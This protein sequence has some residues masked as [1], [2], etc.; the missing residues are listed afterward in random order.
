MEYKDVIGPDEVVVKLALAAKALEADELAL[1]IRM[2][3]RAL[4][5]IDVPRQP[6]SKHISMQPYGLHERVGMLVRFLEIRGF[7][8]EGHHGSDDS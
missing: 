3:H 4:D 5:R 6:D 1:T 8:W 2:A 7:V